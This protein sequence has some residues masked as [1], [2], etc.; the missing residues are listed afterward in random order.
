[1]PL[2]K[3]SLEPTDFAD[4]DC[5]VTRWMPFEGTSPNGYR[6]WICKCGNGY[7]FQRDEWSSE[8]KNSTQMEHWIFSGYSPY[9]TWGAHYQPAPKDEL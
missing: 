1:M 7:W 5:R 8:G 9:R 2:L 4:A 6:I 3:N